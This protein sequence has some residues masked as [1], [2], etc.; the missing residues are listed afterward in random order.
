S[1]KVEQ[2]EGD[3]ASLTM[4]VRNPR[5]GLLAPGRPV[6]A[7]LSW[8]NGHE[9][10]PLFYGRLIG[11]PTNLDQELVEFNF[12]ARPSDF[13]IQKA[14][15]A[16]TLRVRPYWDGIFFNPKSRYEPDNVLESRPANWHVD[17]ITH[18]V[19]ISDITNGED[20]T[21]TYDESTVFDG[22]MTLDYDQNPL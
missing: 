17:R 7:W 6:W 9:T 20:G 1:F 18:E 5:I 12:T 22:T 13:D 2:Q 19:T 10:V 14:A 3:F 8:W 4:T 15:V 11:L 21:V 16:D